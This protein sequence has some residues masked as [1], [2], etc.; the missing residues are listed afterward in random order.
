M[1]ART[2]RRARRRFQILKKTHGRR[3][4]MMMPRLRRTRRQVRCCGKWVNA[5][6]RGEG[7]EGVFIGDVM[8]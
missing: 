3:R 5:K 8:R 1:A 7:E 4:T 6:E 2:A